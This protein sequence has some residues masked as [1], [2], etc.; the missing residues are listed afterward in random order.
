[1]R[2]AED[3]GDEPAEHEGDTKKNAPN[4]MGVKRDGSD[5]SLGLEFSATVTEADAVDDDDAN[6][7]NLVVREPDPTPYFPVDVITPHWKQQRRGDKSSKDVDDVVLSPIEAAAVRVFVLRIAAALTAFGAPTTR[8]EF[9][10]V[11]AAKAMHLR[12]ADIAAFPNWFLAKM[13]TDVC[14]ARSL[15]LCTFVVLKVRVV[16]VLWH[17]HCNNLVSDFLQ[18]R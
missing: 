3:S 8:V 16:F 4:P 17:Q 10:A 6:N 1:M 11:S 9:L 13:S 14:E 5:E 7:D 12:N 18:F 2:A 15:V